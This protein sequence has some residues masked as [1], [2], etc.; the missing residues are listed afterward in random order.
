VVQQINTLTKGSFHLENEW[1]YDLVN[2]IPTSESEVFD[3]DIVKP[4]IT[5]E[6]ALETF[7][8]TESDS[9]FD[10][11]F[12]EE[13]EPDVDGSIAQELTKV[14]QKSLADI[15]RQLKYEADADWAR[16]NYKHLILAQ[17]EANKLKKGYNKAIWE[18][19]DQEAKLALLVA[20]DRYE[21]RIYEHEHWHTHKNKQDLSC[22]HVHDGVKK[23]PLKHS[24]K[25]EHTV[26]IEYWIRF[27]VKR[28]VLNFIYRQRDMAGISTRV[29]SFDQKIL[30]M[31]YGDGG[32]DIDTTAAKM[33]SANYRVSEVLYRPTI[34]SLN[35]R[36]EDTELELLDNII[37]TDEH[38]FSQPTGYRESLLIE[39]LSIL[40]PEELKI[41]SMYNEIDA[42]DKYTINFKSLDFG[43]ID[44]AKDTV[45]FEMIAEHLGKPKTTVI[46]NY[47]KAIK[48][49]LAFYESKKTEE[50]FK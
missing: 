21:P 14:K 1:M 15:E 30:D 24:H 27:V 22:G 13:I 31:Y 19:I 2:H 9:D 34:E 12:M 45:T 11:D 23:Y 49:I 8:I 16:D 44:T 4:S 41:I 40:S 33:G 50:G 7:D 42:V 26:S 25:H 29:R 48:K 47:R 10:L 39:S 6:E 36:N 17:K 18:D 43:G 37:A 46:R 28:M 3:S 20:L 38:D 5:I 35:F 32:G